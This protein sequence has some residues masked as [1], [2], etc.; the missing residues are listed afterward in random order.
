MR[1]RSNGFGLPLLPCSGGAVHHSVGPVPC[2]RLRGVLHLLRRRQGLW[3]L[4]SDVGQSAHWPL[5]LRWG[6]ALGFRLECCH[7]NAAIECRLAMRPHSF[8]RHS[9]IRSSHFRAQG[10]SSRAPTVATLSS[11]PGTATPWRP[12]TQPSPSPLT[13]LCSTTACPAMPRGP[14]TSPRRSQTFSRHAGGA[15][16]ACGRV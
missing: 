5:L 10:R 11:R 3:E 16:A 8:R 1:H 15:V 7:S 4:G 13:W 2:P 12:P 14:A 9:T 6:P